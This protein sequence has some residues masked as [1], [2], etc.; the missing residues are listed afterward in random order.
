LDL[1]VIE[2][3]PHVGNEDTALRYLN[4]YLQILENEFIKKAIEA[5]SKTMVNCGQLPTVKISLF[6]EYC[7]TARKSWIAPTVFSHMIC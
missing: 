1:L 3:L 5:T 2:S 4:N 6:G 7:G